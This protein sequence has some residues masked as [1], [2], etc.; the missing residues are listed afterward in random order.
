MTLYG[1]L[2]AI[3]WSSYKENGVYQKKIIFSNIIY[4]VKTFKNTIF[5]LRN[6]MFFVSTRRIYVRI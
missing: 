2:I 5:L 3:D 4:G 1:L 6:I